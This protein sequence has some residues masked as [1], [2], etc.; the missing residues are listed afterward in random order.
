MRKIF[1]LKGLDCPNCAAKIEREVLSINGVDHSSVN[2]LKQSL[3][4]EIDN[5]KTKEITDEIRSIVASHEPEVEF[6]EY[7]RKNTRDADKSVGHIVFKILFGAAVFAVSFFLKAHFWAYICVLVASYII[8]GI[9]VV[10]KA[11]KNIFKGRIFDE[12][13]LMSI[14][15]VGAF[16]IGEYP[17]AVAVMLFY[18]IGEFFQ[19]IAVDRSRGSIS[20]LMELYCDDVTVVRDGKTVSVALDD[21]TVGEEI[22][23][24]PGEKIAFDG[25]VT[26]GCGALDT[27][28][29]TGESVPQ[30]VGVGDS[31]YS[32]CINLSEALKIKVTKRY[33]E[34]TAAK[35][36]ELVENSASKKAPTENFITTFAGYYTPAVVVAAVLLAVVPSL[37]MG[38]WSQWIHRS[39]VFLVVS[40]PCALVISIPLSFFGGIGAASRHGILVKGSNYIEALTKLSTVVFDKT[41]TLTQGEF[42][43][44]DI[45]TY[46]NFDQDKLLEYSAKA[47]S[48]SNHPL[49]KSIVKTYSN[50]ISP[51]DISDFCE[52]SGRGISAVVMG[53]TVL[54]GNILFLKDNNIKC[55]SQ[56]DGHTAVYV[57][58]NGVFAGCI[59]LKDTVKDDSNDGIQELKELG[60][61][62]TVM[63]TGDRKGIA[64]EVAES[65]GIDEYYAELLP[66][67]KV[68]I[69]EKIDL[70]KPEKTKLAFVGDG[71]NDAPVLARADIG[72]A[73]G[74]L[75]SDAAIEAADVVLMTDSPSK[76]CDAVR[77]SH[78][79]R[80]IAFQNIII[81][82]GVKAVF[83][84]LGAVGYAGMWEAVFADVGVTLIAV[85]NAMRCLKIDLK[86]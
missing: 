8:L 61:K 38:N 43:V 7:V 56:T 55:E 76:I 30:S 70:Q 67:Q 49:A 41:G 10:I 73:M 23:V 68:E 64:K 45:K 3:T 12:N 34:S 80:R 53:K 26:K 13:L 42:S 85:L 37:I 72:I 16:V 83:L 50:E 24:R 2:L 86:R 48:L 47:E 25:V 21:V 35:I 9:D 5:E 60:I 6:S 1:L 11:M 31:V 36:I 51:N 78:A 22:L 44:T 18:Q 33:C 58:I 79:T 65:L 28:A 77:I 75:G 14:S 63:L 52:I 17:E 82:L 39:F 27:K 4:V 54:A 32:G 81:A 74:G 84:L 66:A 59:I 20:N 71:I 69:L 62:K 19:N 57:A 29:L 40:C 46:N 15:T